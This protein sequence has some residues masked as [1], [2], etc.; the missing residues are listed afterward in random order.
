MSYTTQCKASMAGMRGE[1]WRALLIAAF[2]AFVLAVGAS[3]PTLAHA[4]EGAPV[5]L[6]SYASEDDYDAANDDFEYVTGTW[7]HYANGK[8]RFEYDNDSYAIGAA[9]IESSTG[10]FDVYHFDNDG[11]MT[12]GWYK[13]AGKWYY[14]KPSGAMATGWQTVSGKWYYLDPESGYMRTGWQQIGNTWYYLNG[15]G[16]MQ[17]GWQKLGGSWYYLNKS[18][19]M[20]TGWK[21]LG[22][23]WYYL[24]ASGAM[25]TG[26]QQ[27]GGAWYY[28]NGSGVMQTGWQKLGGSWYYLNKS[29]A[30]ATGWKQLGKS[31]YYLKAS[32][33]MATGWQQVGGAWYHMATSGV[34]DS[35]K[36][37]G[38]YYVLA[39]GAM[40]TN[41]WVGS[42]YVGGDGK[43]IRGYGSGS[44]SGAVNSSTVYWT[45]DGKS[46]HK[47][48]DCRSLAKAKT[49]LSGTIAESGKSDPC[50]NCYR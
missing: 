28:L 41:Q 48:K 10:V 49:I 35:K 38:D 9:I 18:G 42:Y 29:G 26:W 19:A 8:W 6:A 40:A 31:W 45:P 32:G 2:V 27:V 4:D 33:A 14:F 36:W 22:K 23:S 13:E 16:V 37:I 44:N 50:N 34:M 17:T 24:K 20:A 39:S 12:T 3:I 1:A 25:A 30:M 47:T 11:W 15:S 43:W 7:M 21:Q 5:P 46:Y